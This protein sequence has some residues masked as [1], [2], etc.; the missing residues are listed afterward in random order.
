MLLGYRKESG[1]IEFLFT[2]DSYLEKRFPNNT[3]KI[4]D[5]WDNNEHGLA[6]LFVSLQEFTNYNDYKLYKVINNQIVKKSEEEIQFDLNKIKTRKESKIIN[7]NEDNFLS[8]DKV[9]IKSLED[10]IKILESQINKYTLT[11]SE[12]K[13][14]K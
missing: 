2:D 5:F 3:A 8:I 10:K 6:E 4:L 9:K 13:N 12:V 11:S 1:E 14:D 7:N